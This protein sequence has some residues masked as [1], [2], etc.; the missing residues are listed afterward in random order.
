M[1]PVASDGNFYGTTVSGGNPTCGTELDHGVPTPFPCGTVFRIT[2]TGQLTTLHTFQSASVDGYGAK[3][4]LL[5]AAN[6]I[7]YGTTSSGGPSNN[8]TV[9]SLAVGLAP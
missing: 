5:Q 6:G 9:F 4:A 8:G 2:P 3:G 1:P 7:L